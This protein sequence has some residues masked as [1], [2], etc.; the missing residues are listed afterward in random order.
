MQSNESELINE[1]IALKSEL[2]LREDFSNTDTL[3]T[4]ISRIEDVFDINKVMKT[5]VDISKVQ[6]Y[7]HDSNIGYN[8]LHSKKG[9][10]HMALNYNGVFNEEGYFQQVYEI[11]GQLVDEDTIL[12]LGCGKGFN[13]F[14]LAKKHPRAS[15]Y[16]IDISSKHLTYAKKKSL[17]TMNLS[18]SYGDFHSIN[19]E[20]STFNL[21][22][23]LESV[24]HSTNPEKL[25]KEVYRILKKGGK[26]ILYEGFRSSQYDK[27]TDLQKKMAVLIEKSMAVHKGHQIDKWL[28]TAIK[29]GFKIEE[30]KDISYAIMPNLIR[31]HR[32]ARKYFKYTFLSKVILAV[33]PSN[34]IKNTIAGLL[35]PF[36]IQQKIQSYHRIILYK[37]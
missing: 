21:V 29:I 36:S 15:F 19:F 4:Y 26:F 10:V 35:M 11:E 32:L 16:G 1:Q 6:N 13:S 2:E 12:E 8:L 24:C 3:S 9:A 30:K 22:F 27:S 17:N 7:Y 31:F 5:N 37:E 33:L 25:L 14:Y 20:D 34:L 18:F 23:E 28:E